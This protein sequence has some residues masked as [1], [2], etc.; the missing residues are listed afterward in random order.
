M[1]KEEEEV[2]FINLLQNGQ[3]KGCLNIKLYPNSHIIRNF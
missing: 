3:R 1:E 2:V